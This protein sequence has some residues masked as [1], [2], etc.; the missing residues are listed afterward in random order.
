M[1]NNLTSIYDIKIIE[2]IMQEFNFPSI[3]CK[4]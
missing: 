1:L 4:D 3:L 2:K